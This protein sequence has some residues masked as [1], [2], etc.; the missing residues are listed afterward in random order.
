M[1]QK[2]ARR[3]FSHIVPL[4]FVNGPQPICGTGTIVNRHGLILT[5]DHVVPAETGRTLL[6]GR[7]LI[8][9]P[10]PMFL[11]Q[12]SPYRRFP[13]HDLALIE[14]S[15]LP[16][17]QINKPVE[18]SFQKLS[19][20]H[21]LGSFGFP[22]PL[23]TVEQIQQAGGSAPNLIVGMTLRF[24][25]YFVAGIDDVD[26]REP[27]PWKSLSYMLDSFAYGGHSGGPV[28]DSEGRVVAVMSKMHLHQR[29]QYEI[30]YCYAKSVANIIN[31]LRSLQAG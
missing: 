7:N 1:F 28:F 6:A 22:Q 23:V 26:Q 20:G 14:V 12:F 31:E 30:S 18:F 2:A 13:E 21:P 15:Q 8:D 5:A 16:M 11:V 27:G 25:S 9:Q 24:K 17:D 4:I 10:P 29:G 19:Y 3:M